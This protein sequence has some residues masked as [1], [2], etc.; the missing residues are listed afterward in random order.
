MSDFWQKLLTFFLG[1]GGLAL[2]SMLQDRWKWKAE[3]KAK[4]EDHE[5]ERAEAREQVERECEI[6]ITEMSTNLSNYITRQET[7]NGQ[8]ADRLLELEKQNSAQNEGMKYVLLD[9]IL[10]LGQSYIRAGAVSYDDR[11][12]LGDM[13]SVYHKKLNGNGDA[14]AIMS[15]VYELPIK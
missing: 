9:R 1:A 13:H 6:K 14:D 4:K 15:S 7:Y 8:L 10:Y 11:K 5:E 2:L 3:R 12:R